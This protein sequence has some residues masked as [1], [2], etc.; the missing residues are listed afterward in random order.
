[1]R[2]NG[3]E[4]MAFKKLI[5][6]RRNVVGRRASGRH[7]SRPG[8]RG[9]RKQTVR[10]GRKARTSCHRATNPFFSWGS[11]RTEKTS[12]GLDAHP[13]REGLQ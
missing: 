2:G 9:G 5:P 10:K 11:E 13:Q 6:E 8:F 12:I 7:R 3:G 1:V 4:I